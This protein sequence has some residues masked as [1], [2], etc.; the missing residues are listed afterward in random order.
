MTGKKKSSDIGLS[1]VFPL[2]LAMTAILFLVALWLMGCSST[3]TPTNSTPLNSATKTP[4]STASN[5]G[6]KY[7]VAVFS[8]DS[9]VATLKLNDLTNLPQV[10]VKAD[11][12][13][14][15]GPTLL[16]VLGLAGIK[17]FSSVTAYG[18]SK[19]RVATAELTLSKAQINEQVVLD[20]SNQ[21][22]AKLAGPD[23]PGNSWIIDVNK[24]V[25][26]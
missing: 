5:S 23:I 15:N 4:T 8:G 14:Q 20:I 25:V 6:D 11:G 26:K 9:Q 2:S 18:Y 1:R 7:F 16:S 10:S 17:D 13:D 21:G 12:K 19:G 24:L 22:T 3:T